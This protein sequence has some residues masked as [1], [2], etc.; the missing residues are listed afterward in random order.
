[1][2]LSEFVLVHGAWHGGWCWQTIAPALVRAGHR[3][4]VMTLT[5]VGER[6]HML[7]PSINLDTH[8]QDVLMAIA[9]EEFKRPVLV[10]HS[11]GG[12]V[13][14][15]VA[16][17]LMAAHEHNAALPSVKELV[18]LDAI[19]P[20]SG[21]SWSSTQLQE[22]RTS[23]IAGANAHPLKGIPPPD[24]SA[25]GLKD[26]D[27]AWVNRQQRPQPLGTYVQGLNFS[28]ERVAKIPRQFIDCVAPASPGIGPSRLRARDPNFWGGGWQV[29]ELQTGHDAMVSAPQALIEAL[30]RGR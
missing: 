18:Y 3:V 15:G 21:E 4:L 30:L 10:G 19:L 11:Y 23:R 2:K 13:I 20:L 7:A 9:A 27:A 8:L 1:M 17:R 29:S 12:M 25:F 22:T 5:G 26:E 28:V 16:D 6:S 24:A 14:T